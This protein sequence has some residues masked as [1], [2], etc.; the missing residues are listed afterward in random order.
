[1]MKLNLTKLHKIRQILHSSYYLDFRKR[2]EIKEVTPEL[3]ARF[4]D[5]EANPVDATKAANDIAREILRNIAGAMK[6]FG[7]MDQVPQQEWSDFRDKTA[8]RVW[9]YTVPRYAPE[10]GKFST[11]VFNMTM[12]MWKNWLKNK[13]NIPLDKGPSLDEPIAGEDSVIGTGIDMLQD[14]LAM[15]FKS[16]V[17]AQII[18][19]ALL[20]NIRSPRYRDILQLWINEDPRN[21]FKEKQENVSKQYNET[22]PDDQIAPYRLYRIMTDEIFPLVLDKFPELA[23]GV[24]FIP[25][26]DVNDSSKRWDRVPKSESVEP[27]T[28]PEDIF[29]E[30]EEEEL[31]IPLSER[32]APAYR[33]NPQTGERTLISSLNMKRRKLT[34]AQ[35]TQ[36]HNLLTF[37]SIVKVKYG[38]FRRTIESGPRR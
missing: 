35:V 20:E 28:S 8:E 10:Q 21:N 7:I 18:E 26:T 29:D 34:A 3:L 33:I 11:L 4:N 22:H 12:N 32:T 15:D 37:L 27:D 31:Y 23:K 38:K 6:H 13:K 14:P 1:M 2:G 25:S 24:G 36:C 9:S 5:Y 19:S 30:D 17:E 16:E